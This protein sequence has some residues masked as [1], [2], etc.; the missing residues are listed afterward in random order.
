LSRAKRAAPT[1][2][3]SVRAERPLGA[4]PSYQI[5]KDPRRPTPQ[6]PRRLNRTPAH[7]SK[8]IHPHPS[9]PA[10]MFTQGS[11][12]RYT[13]PRDFA[14]FRPFHSSQ[15]NSSDPNGTCASRNFPPFR[16]FR[17]Q[18]S[19]RR[20]FGASAMSRTTYAHAITRASSQ[21]LLLAALTYRRF[22]DC[23]L[24]KCHSVLTR[25]SLAPADITW[26]NRTRRGRRSANVA[27][28]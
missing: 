11:L 28:R 17:M 3:P 9:T 22:W 14:V 23:A 27:G 6:A 15:K 16:L 24:R 12:D 13:R 19:G 2:T 26:G 20:F 4:H 1:T 25:F 7:V 10:Q 18:A 21:S 8:S 5:V